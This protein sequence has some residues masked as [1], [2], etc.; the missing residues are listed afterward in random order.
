VIVQPETGDF[1]L[2]R[3]SSHA[4]LAADMIGRG[5]PA[6]SRRTRGATTVLA[7]AR[8]RRRWNDEDDMMPVDAD[9]VPVGSSPRRR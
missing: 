6:A 2:I 3:Q 8:V 4:A 7:A 5:R 9:G 1:V